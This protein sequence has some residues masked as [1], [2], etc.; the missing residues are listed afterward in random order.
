MWV[1]REKS[2][3]KC[4]ILLI[5]YQHNDLG[6]Y[7]DVS[8]LDAVATGFFQWQMQ[9]H[10]INHHQ[11]FYRHHEGY[12]MGP[13]LVGSHGTG[14]GSSDLA[15]D[16]PPR[17]ECKT[18][19]HQR[20]WLLE[21]LLKSDIFVIFTSFLIVVF[22][23]FSLHFVDRIQPQFSRHLPLVAILSSWTP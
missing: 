7:P 16:E 4:T 5:P 11:S 3:M 6:L 22:P 8:R 15:A 17:S 19:G 20:S 14:W 12:T 21:N 23:C 13:L 1:P 9:V 2:H 10:F 18:H